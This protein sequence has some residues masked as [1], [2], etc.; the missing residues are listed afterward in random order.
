MDFVVRQD[1]QCA[2]QLG[3]AGEIGAEFGE[4]APVLEVGEAV[5]DGGASG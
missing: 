4:C 2:Q 1:E 5:F 3:G